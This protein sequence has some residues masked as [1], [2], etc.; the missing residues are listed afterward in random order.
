MFAGRIRLA[1]IFALL[2]VLGIAA[3]ASA[4]DR[5]AV[6][7]SDTVPAKVVGVSA[8][9]RV[10]GDASY[11]ALIPQVELLR[12]NIIANRLNPTILAISGGGQDGAYGAGFLTGWTTTGKRP[13][14]ALVTG[15]S[16][17]ALIAP[18]RF[19]ARATTLC[20]G[21]FSPA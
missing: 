14:F 17:G 7:P 16:A 8:D 1:P 18:L 21:S 20:C 3:C 15:V 2:L 5:V 4:P 11:D 12:R 6:R 13:E 10:F 19:W 9:A